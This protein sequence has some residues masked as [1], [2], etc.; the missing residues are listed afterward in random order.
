M[1]RAAAAEVAGVGLFDDELHQRI[2]AEV[3]RELPGR[4]L[5]DPHE[6]RLDGE[7]PRHS[8]RQRHLRRLDRVVAAVRV[9]RE[10]R[11]AHAA[12]E[13]L[14]AAAIGECRR[15]RQENQIAPGDECIGQ[16]RFLHFEC[17]FAG[18][19]GLADLAEQAEVEQMVFA[20]ALGPVWEGIGQQPKSAL[21][22]I[23]LRSMALPVVEADGLY[24]LMA[25]K[26]PG[27]TGRR[28]LAAGEEHQGMAMH[29][30]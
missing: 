6:R 28:V 9:A 24:A 16:L 18:E 27:K 1:A 8:E 2:T 17:H 7:T 19:R 25:G 10:I 3:L 29:R 15:Q 21:A 11:L 30:K 5:V 12:D 26:G 22:R 23:E 13:H 4:R 20:E 14:D